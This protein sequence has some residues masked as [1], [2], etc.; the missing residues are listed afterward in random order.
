MEVN[1]RFWGSLQL[2]IDAGID[3]P[4]LACELALGREV[5]GVPAYRT[6]VRSRW[7]LGDLDH[8]LLRLF[9]SSRELALPP[10]APSRWQAVVDFVTCAGPDLHDEIARFDDW[11]PVLYEVRQ[12]AA[13]LTASALGRLRARAGAARRLRADAAASLLQTGQRDA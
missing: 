2:A 13:A 4:W 3:F 6:G 10:S 5:G 12:A 9:K 1:G 11:R 7:L 8:L